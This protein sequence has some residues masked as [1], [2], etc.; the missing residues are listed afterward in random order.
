M[1]FFLPLAHWISLVECS[2]LSANSKVDKRNQSLIRAA[3]GCRTEHD[4]RVIEQRRRID[5]VE[6]MPRA[7]LRH[8]HSGRLPMSSLMRNRRHGLHN[9]SR[10][11]GVCL[12]GESDS[13]RAN[14]RQSR[15]ANRTPQACG[16]LHESATRTSRARLAANLRSAHTRDT[17]A[18]GSA[19]TLS[20]ATHS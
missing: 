5:E 14:S 1:L 7:S 9:D 3:S 12:S 8:P 20:L 4:L 17:V 13:D 16:T 6:R 10:Q 19:T 15:H 18:G 11:E 2:L